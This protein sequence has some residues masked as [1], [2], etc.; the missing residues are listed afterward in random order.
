M[1]QKILRGYLARKQHQPR[2]KGITKIKAVMSNM[3]QME[4]IANQLKGEREMV[5]KQIKDIE[6]QVDSA[7]QKIRVC[8]KSSL[9]TLNK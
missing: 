6:I 9:N 4:G 8:V 1:V 2:Y 3:K 5:L 7:I